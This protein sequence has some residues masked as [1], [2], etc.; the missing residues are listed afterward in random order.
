MKK[1]I[2]ITCIK[3]AI[4]KSF[5]AYKYVCVNTILDIYT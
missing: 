5:G 3:N 1:H 2:S 4:D